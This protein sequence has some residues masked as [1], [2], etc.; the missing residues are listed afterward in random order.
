MEV[1]IFGLGIGSDDSCPFW[2]S[3]FHMPFKWAS[4]GEGIR[5]GPRAKP[6]K[7]FALFGD[8][9]IL[10][11]VVYIGCSKRGH[12]WAHR[13]NQTGERVDYGHGWVL[14]LNPN[15]WEERRL[16]CNASGQSYRYGH[17]SPD[18]VFTQLTD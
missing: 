11:T 1:N 7:R 2:E 15:T 5:P 4:G 16:M 18:G 9:L 13:P 17:L 10:A 14:D 3:D 8:G 6:G 12:R